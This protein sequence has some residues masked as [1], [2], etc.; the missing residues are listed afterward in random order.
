MVEIR[1]HTGKVRVTVEARISRS[2]TV[3]EN[4]SLIERET[5]WFEMTEAMMKD[6]NSTLEEQIRLHMKNWLR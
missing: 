4:T 2:Q 1:D 3:P 5:V 6:L